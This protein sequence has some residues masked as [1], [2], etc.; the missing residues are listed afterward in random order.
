RHLHYALPI[1][2]RQLSAE[3]QENCIEYMEQARNNIENADTER[4]IQAVLTQTLEYLQG[5]GKEASEK[6]VSKSDTGEA[7]EE[8]EELYPLGK[9]KD[10]R[11]YTPIS[12][13]SNWEY[14]SETE[15]KGI[16]ETS[17]PVLEDENHT[18][19]VICQDLLSSTK[20]YSYTLSTELGLWCQE[21]GIEAS[22]GEYLTYGSYEDNK[23][24]FYISLNDKNETVLLVTYY[25]KT[26]SW[27]F[28][29]VDNT[30]EE[31]LQRVPTEEGDA[32]L[33]E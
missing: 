12:N 21:Q 29:P 9:E 15:Q 6:P 1:Y 25:K 26:I 4:T 31:I 30:K 28:E 23:E 8:N 11:E 16:T 22:A 20:S 33:P 14:L 2:Y 24:S 13:P 18:I 32:G 3:D 5:R 7:E 10:G 19:D 17:I 27:S